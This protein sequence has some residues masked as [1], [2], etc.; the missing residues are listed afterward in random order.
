MITIKNDIYLCL[1]PLYNFNGIFRELSKMFCENILM[2]QFLL[3]VFVSIVVGG[4]DTGHWHNYITT[5]QH[6]QL[7][8]PLHHQSPGP[9]TPLVK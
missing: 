2:M 3:I 8:L 4:G 1:F 5:L 7:L 9:G 6:N